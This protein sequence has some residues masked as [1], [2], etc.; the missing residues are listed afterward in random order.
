MVKLS[1]RRSTPAHVHPAE[2]RRMGGVTAYERG[3]DEQP[4][5]GKHI[6]T[7]EQKLDEFM[8]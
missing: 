5:P 2:F 1:V 8:R 6:S 4:D 3:D 7:I